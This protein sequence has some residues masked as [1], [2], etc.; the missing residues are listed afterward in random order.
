M[1]STEQS[2]PSELNGNS[3]KEV[4]SDKQPEDASVEPVPDTVVAEDDANDDFQA[5]PDDLND[6]VVVDE[7][8]ITDPEEEHEIGD[9]ELITEAVQWDCPADRLAPRTYVDKDFQPTIRDPRCKA[10]WPLATFW[11]VYVGNFRLHGKLGKDYNCAH[12]IHKYFALKGIP[13]FVVFRLKNNFFKEYQQLVGLYDMLV[14]FCCEKDANRAIQW[15]HRDL[16]FGYRLNVYS[17]R[18]PVYFN[19]YKSWRF[20]HIKTEDKME[21]EATLEDYFQRFGDVLAVSKQDLDGVFVQFRTK[22]RFRDDQSTFENDRFKGASVEE[23][24]QRQRFVEQ[25]VEAE[26]LKEIAEVP[27]FIRSRPRRSVMVS[28]M[29]GVIPDLNRSWE[30]PAVKGYRRVETAS[31][32][33]KNPR[34]KERSHIR[35]NRVDKAL[36][37]GYEI[38]AFKRDFPVRGKKNILFQ[39]DWKKSTDYNQRHPMKKPHRR[40]H[41]DVD[42]DAFTR[43]QHRAKGFKTLPVQFQSDKPMSKRR[44]ARLRPKKQAVPL[45]E[46]EQSP[47]VID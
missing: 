29:H 21:T 11:P 47:I 25:D 9:Y 20:E 41:Y 12:A 15:C 17:G 1:S 22:I 44:A 23:R 4:V 8:E 6:F 45:P 3:E 13:S 36:F 19:N 38:E 18:T 26:I 32:R 10:D 27:Q 42:V 40:A 39:R 43:H 7:A 28:L 5:M 16:Y 33:S 24:V 46:R 35:L 14:Y 37:A 31:T 2:E 34:V 30:N